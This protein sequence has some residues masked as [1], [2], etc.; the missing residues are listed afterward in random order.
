MRI[1]SPKSECSRRTRISTT[2]LVI[3]P[4]P[5]VS[6]KRNSYLQNIAGQSGYSYPSP[7]RPRVPFKVSELMHSLAF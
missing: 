3:Q 2:S 4:A 6:F 7:P 1:P 5:W